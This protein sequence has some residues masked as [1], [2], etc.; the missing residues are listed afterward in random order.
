MATSI[1]E[2][3]LDFQVAQQIR[4]IRLQNREVREALK[5]LSRVDAQLKAAIESASIDQGQFTAARLNA[6]KLQ[7]TELINAIHAQLTPVLMGNV[8]DAAILSAE[9]EEAMLNRILPAGLDVTTPNLGVL[10]MAPNLRP[11]NGAVMAD[12]VEMLRVSDL[13]RT[14]RAILDGITSGTTTEDLIRELNGSRALRYKDGIRE[15]S[16]RGLEALVRT[17]INHATNQGRQLVWEANQDIIGS[18]RWVATLD[19]RTTPICQFRD[20][21]VGPVSQDGPWTP[22]PG[23]DVLD[24]PMARPPAHPNC[25]STTVAV[26]KSWRELG[27]D[28]DEMDPGTRASMDGQVPA[29]LTYYDWLSRQSA[30][31]QKDVVG[32]AR[33]DMWKKDGITPDRFVNDK[34][35]LL[36][37]DE[38]KRLSI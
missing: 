35:R 36:T 27:F 34:G 28:M 29:N 17:S 14:W 12:W 9:I 10:Q 32:P 30:A 22:P 5:I 13:S 25:R 19:S 4:W 23:A 21:R 2:R 20:G 11:F 6:L 3:F 16:R 8:R 18:V 33:Y 15:V 26:T 37:L 24:P 7:I 38:L 1:N 31:V